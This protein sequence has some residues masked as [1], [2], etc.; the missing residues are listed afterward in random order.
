MSAREFPQ[1]ETVAKKT[2]QSLFGRSADM[3]CRM[4]SAIS[5]EA[6]SIY[7]K[8]IHRRLKGAPAAR[9][10]ARRIDLH[11][12]VFVNAAATCATKG[13]MPIRWRPHRLV[14]MF[15]A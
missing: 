10:K 4:A 14:L 2:S 7:E 5:N 9:W 12:T 11:P 3:H 13:R 1:K 8:A 6:F 15:L